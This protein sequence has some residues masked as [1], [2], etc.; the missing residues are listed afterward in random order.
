MGF[1]LNSLLL[2]G[3]GDFRLVDDPAPQLGGNLD[4]NGYSIIGT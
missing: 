3:N 2:Q 4:I 1:L